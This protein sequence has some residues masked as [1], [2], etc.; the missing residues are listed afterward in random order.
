MVGAIGSTKKLLVY[1]LGK[2]SANYEELCT[3]LCDIE[4]VLN[5]HPLTYVLD[6]I[7]DLSP[8]TLSM[9][10]QDLK[11]TEIPELGDINQDKR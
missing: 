6:D 3:I 4:V 9:F 1:V 2:S 10:L 11:E 5:N 7:S 8:L